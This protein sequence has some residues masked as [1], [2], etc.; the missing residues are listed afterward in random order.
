MPESLLHCPLEPYKQRYTE[1]L[2]GWE[3]EAF[4]KLFTVDTLEPQTNTLLNVRTGH[5][6]DAIQRPQW[7][8]SQVAMLLNRP[9]AMGLGKIY[10]SDFFHPG[11][12]SL[13]YS[14][15]GFN[16]SSFC[17]A[18]SF[19]RFDFTAGMMGWMRPWEVMAFDIYANVFVASS[20]LKE[21]IVSALPHVEDKV[22][23]VGLPFNSKQ[24]STLWDATKVPDTEY[25][26]VYSSRWDKEKNPGFFLDLVNARPDVKF[27]VCCPWDALRGTDHN[28]V[29]RAEK[30]RQT[31]R[32]FSV[33]TGLSKPEYYAI[34]NKCHVQFNCAWQDWVSFTLLEA[35]TYQCVPLYPNH[36]SF[37]EALDWSE[38]NLYKPFDLEEASMKLD[39]LLNWERG[40]Q[41]QP[42]LDYHDGTLTRISEYLKAN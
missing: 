24:V 39:N 18:Q 26:V 31:H 20:L 30:M 33:L 16:A 14:L 28:A 17:W 13:P 12:E 5:V 25:Q 27:V 40:N 1:H 41:F 42:V 10:F 15:R 36:R 37:P 35:L 32:N 21:L 22:H 3:R 23:V 9:G 6:L 2:S 38:P 19:D 4:G 8:M 34:L 11:L 7:A 29:L